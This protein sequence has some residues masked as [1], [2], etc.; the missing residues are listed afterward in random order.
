M[1]SLMVNAHLVQ[2]Q[3]NL[4]NRIIR[5][6]TITMKLKQSVNVLLIALFVWS[7]QSSTVHFQHHEIEE[8]VECSTCH[9]FEKLN[10]AH[11]STSVIIVNEN[12]AIKA[13]KHVEKVVI[14]SRFDYRG[15]AE[16]K[17]VDIVGNRQYAVVTIPLGYLSTAPPY[18]TV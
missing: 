15:K 13:R 11:H 10:L 17:L 2:H 6:E 8:V 9:T 1:S 18:T 12:L 16:Y 5:K 4:A 3:F 14:K 7:F